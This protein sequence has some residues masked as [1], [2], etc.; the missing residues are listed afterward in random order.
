MSS[1]KKDILRCDEHP[2]FGKLKTAHDYQVM[3][4]AV[5]AAKERKKA[6][7]AAKFAA[8]QKKA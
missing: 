4:L 6:T 5:E 1:P 2:D 8:A 7:W 3:R